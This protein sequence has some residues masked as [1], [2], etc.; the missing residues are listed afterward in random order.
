S[1]FA[2][3][4]KSG[5]K[6][7]HSKFRA[8][9]TLKEF[10]SRLLDFDFDVWAI[11]ANV[12]P[13]HSTARR[14]AKHFASGHVKNASVPGAGHLCASE[15]ALAQRPAH[16]R[17]RVIDR[18]KRTTD[19]EDCNLFTI[20]LDHRGLAGRNVVG[21]GNSYEVWHQSFCIL[22]TLVELPE[23]V[24]LS[25]CRDQSRLT[26]RLSHP[27]SVQLRLDRRLLGRQLFLP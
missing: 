26:P 23:V 9:S 15:F 19:V 5:D 18:V 8:C 25:V 20:D 10:F 27:K 16:V 1:P 12:I 3:S 11:D 24:S 21:A 22:V 4:S 7:P 6:S 17:A 2:V 14:W 13:I